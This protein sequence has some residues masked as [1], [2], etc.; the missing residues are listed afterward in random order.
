MRWRS[1][2]CEIVSINGGIERV[3]EITQ[4]SVPTA[5]YGANTFVDMLS[6]AKLVNM[7]IFGTGTCYRPGCM[8]QVEYYFD[9]QLGSNYELCTTV[10]GGAVSL[11]F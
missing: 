9:R 8:Y 1:T 2:S 7:N 4:N 6:V 3:S 10:L 5:K 11:I